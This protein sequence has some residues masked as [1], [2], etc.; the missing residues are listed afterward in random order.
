VDAMKKW[1]WIIVI[2]L[3]IGVI[4][5]FSIIS[6]NQPLTVVLGEVTQQSM[7]E[8]IY[9]SGKLET[10]ET[11]SLYSDTNGLIKELKVKEGDKIKK[12]QVLIT[13]NMDSVTQALAEERVSLE[14][15]QAERLT[16]K[17]DH[18]KKFQQQQIENQDAIND[19]LNLE[20]FDLRIKTH[21]IKINAMEKKLVK[22]EI[23]ANADGTVTELSVN[24]GQL[25]SEGLLILKV[26]DFSAYQVVADIN[27][28]EAGKVKL[29]MP[30]SISGES[31]T[32]VY[33]GKVSK[34]ASTAVVTDPAYKD[35]YVATTIALQKVSDELRPGY[36]V[37]VELKIP[38]KQRV[39][40]P[41]EAVVQSEGKSYIY[42]VEQNQAVKV[43][44][45]TGK[46]ND[47]FYEVV[48]GAALG[49][50]IVIKDVE[51]LEDGSKVVVQ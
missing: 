4:S 17:Q 2:V 26:S 51:L 46:E 37:N 9:V 23:K 31:F 19:P 42:K 3:I 5:S 20:Q 48:T 12:G 38:D 49:D 15:T 13:L 34:M 21:N 10:K 8:E 50:K 22:D 43:E 24:S 6:M 25:I 29:G 16:A 45:Q 30:V 18:F 35:A 11:T 44:I 14:I 1:I 36:N 32:D 39:V 41:L 33:E 47:E 40:V 27:E 7:A 28:I